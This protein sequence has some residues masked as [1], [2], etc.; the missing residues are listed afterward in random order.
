MKRYVHTYGRKAVEDAL[1]RRGI[2]ASLYGPPFAE[3]LGLPVLGLDGPDDG[4]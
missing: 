4:P 3:K 1:A 2:A